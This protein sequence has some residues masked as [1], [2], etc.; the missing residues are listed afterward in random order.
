VGNWTCARFDDQGEQNIAK[1]WSADGGSLQGLANRYSTSGTH[2]AVRGAAITRV[3]QSERAQALLAQ[4]I[5]TEIH[6]LLRL[7]G[8][9]GNDEADRQANQAREAGGDTLRE[10]PYTSASNRAR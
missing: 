5:A 2:S 9:P 4:I 6:C 7:S 8:V 1:A 3:D 10:W